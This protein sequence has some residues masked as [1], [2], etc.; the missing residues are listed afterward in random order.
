VITLL[1]S[2]SNIQLFSTNGFCAR[3]MDDVFRL[4]FYMMITLFRLGEQHPALQHE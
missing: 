1:G 4:E 3:V 2:A